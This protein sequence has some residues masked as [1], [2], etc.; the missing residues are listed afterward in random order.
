MEG[1]VVVLLTF[2]DHSLVLEH[3]KIESCRATVFAQEGDRLAGGI[4]PYLGRRVRPDDWG[5]AHRTRK[6]GSW[7]AVCR[8]TDCIYAP[9]I[10]RGPYMRIAADATFDARTSPTGS[11]GA[12]QLHAG[13]AARASKPRAYN[14]V[15]ELRSGTLRP[16]RWR[17]CVDLTPP[18]AIA[19]NLPGKGS[20]RAGSV[21]LYSFRLRI[22]QIRRKLVSCIGS[23]S[24]LLHSAPA[25][26]QANTTSSKVPRRISS[27]RRAAWN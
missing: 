14:A 17:D 25:L 8:K 11:L 10:D 24:S 9:V 27:M 13:Q 20:Q 7:I 16:G 12:G 23:C 18:V 3:H 1:L 26:S 22:V 15:S 4:A 21:T 19:L 2:F 5:V 6:R